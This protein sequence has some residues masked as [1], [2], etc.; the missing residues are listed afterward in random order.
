MLGF[1]ICFYGPL[2]VRL[3]R[4]TYR[5]QY[6]QQAFTRSQRALRDAQAV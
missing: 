4:F 1:G 2:Q 6:M 3:Q 5:M